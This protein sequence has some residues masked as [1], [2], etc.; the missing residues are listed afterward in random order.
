MQP[1]RYEAT[2]LSIGVTE[3]TATI[4]GKSQELLKPQKPTCSAL[5][6]GLDCSLVHLNHRDLTPTALPP[7][8]L[9]AR[10]L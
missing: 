6:D 2:S 10:R 7:A 3:S 1:N 9:T 5:G 4:S 8:D